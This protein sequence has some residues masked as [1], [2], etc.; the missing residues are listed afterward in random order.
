MLK[1]FT[2]L[3]LLVSIICCFSCKHDQ[4]ENS[5]QKEKITETLGS[6]GKEIS[7]EKRIFGLQEHVYELSLNKGEFVKVGLSG[8][9][10]NLTVSLLGEKE[11]ILEIDDSQSFRGQESMPLLAE[12]NGTYR[13]EIKSAYDT[14]VNGKYVLTITKPTIATE[15]QASQ[16]KTDLLFYRARVEKRKGEEASTKKSLEMWQQALLSYGELQDQ[17]KQALTLLEIARNHASLGD[18]KNA[19]ANFEKS[20]GLANSEL[21][22]RVLNTLGLNYYDVGETKKALDL[23]NQALPLMKDADD[24]D[25]EADCLSN[26]GSVYWYLLD[27]ERA[28][29]YYYRA[30]NCWKPLG[31]K[32]DL[33]LHNLATVC[34]ELGE[35]DTA[36]KYYK[37]SLEKVK[38]RGDKE[39]ELVTRIMFARNRGFFGD[40]KTSKSMYSD[41]I[42][43]AKSVGNVRVTGILLA[44]LGNMNV[45]L[46]E[47]NEA[48]SF[49]EETLSLIEK[50][51][52]KKAQSI[53]EVGLG[54]VYSLL[55]E[56]AKA[57]EHLEKGLNITREVGEQL[58]EMDALYGIALIYRKEGNIN[59]SLETTRKALDILESIRSRIY[60]FRSKTAY[61]ATVRFYYDLYIDNLV[62][63]KGVDASIMETFTASEK[64]KARAFTENLVEMSTKI[65]NQIDPKLN[66]EHRE[67]LSTLSSKLQSRL[68]AVKEGKPKADLEKIDKEI[69]QVTERIQQVEREI[70]KVN[71]QYASLKY[72]PIVTLKEVQ[73]R[74]IDNETLLVEYFL[75]GE[76]S[77]VWVVGTQ[78]AKAYKL[79]KEKDIDD[80]AL[81][82]QTL[83]SERSRKKPFEKESEKTERVKVADTQ[84]PAKV[85][86]LSEILLEPIKKEIKD[87]RLLIVADGSLHYIPFSL[88][89]DPADGTTPLIVNHEVINVASASALSVLE[90]QRDRKI[91]TQKTLAIFADPIF[92][93]TD[94]RY[95]KNNKNNVEQLAANNKERD[96]ERGFSD[97]FDRSSDGRLIYS[98][99]EA[100]VISKFTQSDQVKVYLDTAANLPNFKDPD[101]SIYKYIHLATH[102]LFSPDHPELSGLMLSRFDDQ[103]KP[104]NGFIS[105]SEIY[106][107]KLPVEMVVLSACQTG[108]GKNL[109]GEGV[110]G[111]TRGFMY[112]GAKRV[113]VSLWNVNDKATSDLM[114]VFYQQMLQENKTPAQ[115]LRE[116]QIQISKSSEWSSPYYW[117]P[118]VIY[119]E[120]K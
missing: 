97:F 4:K 70:S 110:V 61:F 82:L 113:V 118:F 51:S 21:K 1:K 66:T 2:S 17:T 33:I 29:D 120:Y 55:G 64:A 98:R 58:I 9:E 25:G 40:F 105:A 30:L 28:R 53:A 71:I 26:I 87:K 119:G 116:A 92:S 73:S 42:Q 99:K 91:T 15:K 67:L 69:D 106:T 75:G 56:N 34:D 96:S 79:P 43:L 54:K 68:D 94:P 85:K 77:Y 47:I 107:L 86:A 84:L 5:S 27:P 108:L 11:N 90:T 39:G 44:E 6:L 31:I 14:P 74:L 81:S 20:L 72:S 104:Q 23:L 3:L 18:H 13:V 111:L 109:R 112:A 19:V 89:L 16:Y 100:E 117:A 76:N 114:T 57:L 95:S 32:L 36:E 24:R 80:I 12:S 22:P 93:E 60:T 88:L 10:A 49:Y 102:G 38:E 46:G 41:C 37:E 83:L 48:K 101:L 59:K 7:L 52:D 115:A 103:G 8:Q 65:E 78:F 63:L 35:Y 62:Q 45:R 50:S